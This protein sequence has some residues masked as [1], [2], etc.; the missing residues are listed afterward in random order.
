VKQPTNGR[1]RG[2][3][4]YRLMLF[5]FPRR[6][7]RRYADDMI[8]FYR[9]RVAGENGRPAPPLLVVWAQLIPDLISNAF[10]ERFAWLHRELDPAP[11]IARQY[12]HRR[13][14]TMSI[15][16]QD[17]RYALRGMLRQP[18][19]ALVLVATLALGIGANTAIFT[20]VNAVLLRPLPFAEPDRLIDLSSN[21]RNG[22][23]SV[24]EPE[25]VDYKRGVTTVD[26][27]A[28][29]SA[30]NATITVPGGDPTRAVFTR[31]SRDFFDVL[32]VKAELGR[33]FAADE[34]SPQS[35]ALVTVLSHRL[36]V[37]QFASDPRVIGKKLKIGQGMATIVGVM[38]ARFVFPDA[39]TQLWLSW[40]MNPDSLWTRNNHYLDVVGH[41]AP[42][43]TLGQA[44]AQVATL[45]QRWPKDFPETYPA[46]QPIIR[47]ARPLTDRMLGATRPYLLSL[48]GAVAFILLIACV[49]VANLLLVRGESRRKE[50]AIR[51]ALGASGG[52]MIRQ[53]LT[54]SMMLALIGAVC[55]TV[56]AFVGTRALVALAPADLPRVA[57]IGVDGRVAAFTI[58]ITLFTGV[59]FGL[60]PALRALKGDSADTLRE[61]GKTSGHG[62]SALARR[63]L[64]VAEITLAVVMLSGAGLLVRSLYN[65]QSLD[66]GFD[67][68]RV[69]TMQVTLP[70]NAYSDTT[71]NIYFNQALERARR[72]PGVKSAAAVSYLPITGSDNGWSIMVDN[73]VLKT[74][75]ESPA[76]RPEHVTPGYFSTMGITVRGREF[77]EQDRVDAAPVAIVD[78]GLAKKLWPGKDPIGHTIKMFSEQAVWATVIGVASDVRARGLEAKA[79]ETMYF[80]YAQSTQTAY[81]TPRSMTLI[82]RA[83]NDPSTLVAPLRRIARDLDK[84]VAISRIA[85]MESIVGDSIASRRF[86]TALL[87]GFAVLALALAGIAIYGVISYGVSQ[88]TYEI[89]VRMAMGAS[90][91]SI[92]R[93]VVSEGGSMAAI[94]LLLGLGSALAVERLLRTMLVGVDTTDAPTLLG[95]IVV[96]AA[97]ATAA[98]ALPARRATAVSP[99]EALRNS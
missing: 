99:T 82:V 78:E 45:N 89:G 74:I 24:S 62:A 14:D 72:L 39:E 34:F 75:A 69:L 84:S 60:I 98:C 67:P 1:A 19:F 5:A 47:Q 44:R 97:V 86:A 65:L 38:P 42:G 50:L 88:R 96:L 68:S 57:E 17:I 49:N 64:V 66:L 94:G 28:A 71:A 81:V 46:N 59:A 95:V 15:L 40:R 43:A 18:G 16:M 92:V 33:V 35:R 56:L 48:L 4:M 6:F 90:P 31:V 70:G 54:E 30:N 2:E 93:L 61:G 26:R 52:R 73:L 79:P 91:A 3:W 36:W 9:E 25:F 22:G 37:Q 8:A 58:A 51:T 85:T 21:D 55:G 80:A 83:T 7:R 27:L 32:G 63:S 23:E 41:L 20:V 11:R 13:E 29:Y 76:A 12:S 77:T 87:A 10:A 53:T